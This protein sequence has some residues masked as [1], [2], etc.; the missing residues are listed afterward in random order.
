MKE[1]TPF[2]NKKNIYNLQNNNVKLNSILSPGEVNKYYDKKL[3]SQLK[4][5]QKYKTS[6]QIGQNNSINNIHYLIPKPNNLL[7]NYNE[8]KFRR[9]SKSKEKKSGNDYKTKSL[10]KKRKKELLINKNENIF[11]KSTNNI[12]NMTNDSATNDNN[13]QNIN[14]N[15]DININNNNKTKNNINKDLNI[16]EENKNDEDSENLSKLAEELLSMSDEYN[17]QLMR[18]KPINK[19]DFL[20]KSKVIFNINNQINNNSKNKN[21]KIKSNINAIN[22]ENDERMPKL[23]T[24]LYISP[25]PK[26]H[27]KYDDYNSGKIYNIKNDN[28][29]SNTSRKV[30]NVNT[31]YDKDNYIKEIKEK[32]YTKIKTHISSNDLLNNKNNY[33]VASNNEQINSPYEKN[34]NNNFNDNMFNI[35]LY[36]NESMSNQNHSLKKVSD[37]YINTPNSFVHNKSNITNYDSYHD[38]SN[39][40]K[41]IDN[42]TNTNNNLNNIDN[43]YTKKNLTKS[44][45]R[46]NLNDENEQYK[47]FEYKRYNK[48]QNNNK[49]INNNNYES[50]KDYSYEYI[51]NRIKSISRKTNESFGKNA[52]SDRKSKNNNPQKNII[53]VSIISLFSSNVILLLLSLLLFLFIL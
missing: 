7:I 38:I 29:N 42:N 24:Q 25:L 51:K 22:F 21:N 10:P 52:I 39:N 3:I 2:H 36:L 37:N 43:Y 13:K 45:M 20:G 19:S 47:I 53:N 50:N 31:N 9:N 44:F 32:L 12:P 26:M 4:G 41:K 30:E 14:I 8:V 15:N 49:I 23:Q 48:M 28:K 33:K 5:N 1:K 27:I 17:V 35:D 18:N 34:N 11:S 46:N 6:N 16:K 40:N